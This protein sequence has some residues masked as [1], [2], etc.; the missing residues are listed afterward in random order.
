MSR[1]CGISYG[2]SVARRA[3]GGA[4]ARP[5]ARRWCRAS[6]GLRA[7]ALD[8]VEPDS[9]MAE[10]G[11]REYTGGQ[12]VVVVAGLGVA[13]TLG[14][15]FFTRRWADR[16]EDQRWGRDREAEE[17]RWHREQENRHRQWQ[18]EDSARWLNERRAIYA[19]YLLSISVW[20]SA[21]WGAEGDLLPNDDI[22]NDLSCN[23]ESS[24][25]T[26]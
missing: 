23:A 7:A 9:A 3:S 13:G 19:D 21:L 24:R 5:G 6:G 20:T 18:R 8:L 22:P 2:S 25:G 16:R 12:L 14:G 17:M 11:C 1:A 26:E 15:T 4:S 10:V